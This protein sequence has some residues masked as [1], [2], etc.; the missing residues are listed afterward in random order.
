MTDIR[1]KDLKTPVNVA[2]YLFKRLHEIGI[3]SVHG[4]PGDFNLVALDYL[5]KAGLKWVG[6]VNELNAG[7][8]MHRLIDTSQQ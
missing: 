5:P 2:E 1:V 7:V 4:V 6:S 8:Y 3:R